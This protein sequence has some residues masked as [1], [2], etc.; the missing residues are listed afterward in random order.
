MSAPAPLFRPEAI[1]HQRARGSRTELIV[2]DARATAWGFRLLCAGML[3]L[4]AFIA[5]GRVNEY[6]SGPAFVQ[7]DGR[8]TLT[9]T[10]SG[11][12]TSVSVKPGDRVEA[13]A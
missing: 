9:A 8:T 6:A 10:E 11:L 13:G 5:L 12:V 2:L 1:E 3:A 4:L 7:L